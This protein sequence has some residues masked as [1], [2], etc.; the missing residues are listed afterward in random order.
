MHEKSK[1]QVTILDIARLAGVNH[2][3]VSR[4]LN[5]SPLISAETKARIL[6]IATEL[7]FQFNANA[8]AL[9][10]RKT[11]T[12]AVLYPTNY[13]DPRNLQYTKLLLHNIQENLAEHGYDTLM[14]T[15]LDRATGQSNVRRLISCGKIDGLVMIGDTPSDDDRSILAS[16]GVPAILVDPLA[17][18]EGFDVYATN[19]FI[20][21]IEATDFLLETGR[22]GSPLTLSVG[23]GESVFAQRTAGF[24]R[25][26]LNHGL[27]PEGRMRVVPPGSVFDEGFAYIKNALP[28]L[29]KMG[30]DGIFAQADLLALGVI[31]ALKEEGISVPGDVRVVGF[32]DATIATYFQP[33]LTTMHQPREEIARSATARLAYLIEAEMALPRVVDYI[34][35]RLV[36]RESC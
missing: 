17:E 11:D 12:A 29:R 32:D 33:R 15:R 10:S 30:I 23:S 28:E 4:C 16:S 36:R 24:S 35:P 31:S 2:S 6:K 21:G 20:G 3:T 7:N 14:T 27:S 13:D 25:S 34:P 22:C 5:N 9:V 1:S 8:R 18:G 26:L 19:N